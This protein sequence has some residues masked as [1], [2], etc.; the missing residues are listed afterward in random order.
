M[1]QNSREERVMGRAKSW[2]NDAYSELTAEGTWELC[3]T[4]CVTIG[5]K[6]GVDSLPKKR[7]E[8]GMQSQ[9]FPE[10]CSW[11]KRSGVI[12]GGWGKG[13]REDL[14]KMREIT[15]YLYANGNDPG[16]RGKLAKQYLH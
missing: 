15:L 6:V 5:V 8:D 2:K 4:L 13:S 7:D 1:S 14:F 11:N 3:V 10:F 12:A 16:E 9:H